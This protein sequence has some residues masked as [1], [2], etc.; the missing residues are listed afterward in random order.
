MYLIF[1]SINFSFIC[2]CLCV[3]IISSVGGLC[4]WFVVC[5]FVYVLFL[6]FYFPFVSGF[7]F[8]FFLFFGGS[9]LAR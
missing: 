4:F 1:P 6:F 2:C 8:F 3:G 9:F 5:L 7:F